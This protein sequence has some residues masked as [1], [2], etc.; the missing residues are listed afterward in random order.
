[1]W[2]IM[3]T[4]GTGIEPKNNSNYSRSKRFLEGIACLNAGVEERWVV[5]KATLICFRHW[6]ISQLL[7][8]WSIVI[9][10]PV[11][12]LWK[13]AEDGPGVWAATSRVEDS[14]GAP[15]ST[16]A[17][18]AIWGV[19]QQTKNLSLSLFFLILISKWINKPLG[20]KLPNWGCWF[21]LSGSL[22]A[23]IGK[24]IK[25]ALI[26]TVLYCIL[27]SVT[28]MSLVLFLLFKIVVRTPYAFWHLVLGLCFWEGL[29]YWFD[30]YACVSYWCFVSFVIM[31]QSNVIVFVGNL[32]ISF[33]F[34]NLLCKQLSSE[35]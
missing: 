8:L 22:P 15:C 12:D 9:H 24:A 19:S 10:I 27:K 26:K 1:M 34:S 21:C 7:H 18:A 31:T 25:T 29:S 33:R 30:L 32:S 14:V 5:G 3:Q 20:N 6:S 17:I 2:F 16:L 35:V 11:N 4:S 23:E 13:A 28:V